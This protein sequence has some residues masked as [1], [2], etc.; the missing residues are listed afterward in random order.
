M[1]NNIKTTSIVFRGRFEFFP[2]ASI[3]HSIYSSRKLGNML[4]TLLQNWNMLT[5]I[6][7]IL[8]RPNAFSNKDE[9]SILISQ[10]M[11]VNIELC[12]WQQIYYIIRLSTWIRE[13]E[14][15][16]NIREYRTK[17]GA[18]KQI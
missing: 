15:D 10:N 14:A 8:K 7:V 12:S 6:T 13:Y 2:T 1:H 5:T 11:K 9:L 18:E 17:H 16:R 3:D 4:L